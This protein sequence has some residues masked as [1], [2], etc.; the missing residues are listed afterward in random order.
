[1]RNGQKKIKDGIEGEITSGTYSPF[2]KK[3]IGLARIPKDI[4][5]NAQVLIRNKLLNVRI[6]SLPFVRK[7]KIM[8]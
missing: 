6:L 5:D 2:M 3:S 7:G 4:S 8:V 1:M